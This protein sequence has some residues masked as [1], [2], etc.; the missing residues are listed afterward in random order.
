MDVQ[1]AFLNG[2]ID[3]NIY[4]EQPEG[5]VDPDYLCKLQKS[6]YGLKQSACCWND[7]L[8]GYLKSRRYRKSGADG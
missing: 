7:T 4:M 1:T 8:D 3:C 2:D 5:F 6:I